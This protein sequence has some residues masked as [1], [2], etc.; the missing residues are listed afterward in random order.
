MNTISDAIRFL[1]VC[2]LLHGCMGSTTYVKVDDSVA[3]HLGR[4]IGEEIKRYMESA[5]K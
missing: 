5:E 4:S 2:I 1:A 3:E